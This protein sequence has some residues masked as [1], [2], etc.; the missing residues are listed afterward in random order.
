MKKAI[1]T[2]LIFVCIIFSG[3]SQAKKEIKPSI[4]TP[5]HT[6]FGV[7]KRSQIIHVSLDEDCKSKW[8][9]KAKT[10]RRGFR[11]R[12]KVKLNE[13]EILV[14]LND[15]LQGIDTIE[16]GVNE[17]GIAN[18]MTIKLSSND[19]SSCATSCITSFKINKSE[20]ITI[21]LESGKDVHK[22]RPCTSHICT[23]RPVF[24]I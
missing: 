3:Q 4:V 5:T 15:V 11:F 13:V 19:S 18:K 23:V 22:S 6:F 9:V 12:G 14:Y 16:I 2:L 20:D 17:N 1:L 24:L 21:K 8:V 7:K 10:K